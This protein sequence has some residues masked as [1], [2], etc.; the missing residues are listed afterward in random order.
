MTQFKDVSKST[1]KSILTHIY[2]TA[3]ECISYSH[4]PYGDGDES[5]RGND[6]TSAT[7][8]TPIKIS[9]GD[10]KEGAFDYV[11]VSRLGNL[12]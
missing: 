1:F 10:G 5:F 4:I 11:K 7:L 2:F 8:K 9:A 12:T 3:E 6:V